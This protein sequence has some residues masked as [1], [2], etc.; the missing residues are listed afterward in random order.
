MEGQTN[1]SNHE[2]DLVKLQVPFV[3]KYQIHP[4]LFAGIVLFVIFVLY[5]ICGGLVSIAFSKLLNKPLLNVS[6]L[7]WS[8][9]IGQL[10]FILTPTVIFAKL[11]TPAVRDVF[12][13]RIPTLKES[14]FALLSM[15]ILQWLFDVY[16]ELQNLIPVPVYIE[17]LLRPWKEMILEMTKTIALAQSIPELILVLLVV[18]VMPSIIEEC[19]FRGLVQRTFEYVFSP[20][21][22]AILSGVLFGIFHLNPF[23]LVP[24]VGIGIF[25]ALLRYRSQTLILPIVAHFL[26]N[27]VAIFA[28]Y[29]GYEEESSALASNLGTFGIPILLLYLLVV[30]VIFLLAFRMYLQ[31]TRSLHQPFTHE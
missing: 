19:L 29:M 21:V 6:V 28:L 31:S 25:L 17:E 11:L 14:T 27:A 9:V 8:A 1:N 4:L 16:K 2:K 18:A 23:D 13:M 12:R 5:Q 7:R 30:G 20:F 15:L 3:E 10:F 22:A 26:N 24:L